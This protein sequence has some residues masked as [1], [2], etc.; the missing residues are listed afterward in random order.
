MDANDQALNNFCCLNM[1]TFQMLS[2]EKV[3]VAVLPAGK[4]DFFAQLHY[5]WKIVLVFYLNF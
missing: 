4:N 5:E 1:V 2:S 3:N